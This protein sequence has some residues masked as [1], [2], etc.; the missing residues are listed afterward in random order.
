MRRWV[1]VN[2]A[3][4]HGLLRSV[5]SRERDCRLP[6]AGG[7]GGAILT[8]YEQR[9]SHITMEAITAPPQPDTVQ[10]P[11]LA[12]P[13]FPPKAWRLKPFPIGA[14]LLL[15]SSSRITTGHWRSKIPQRLWNKL[16]RVTY[17]M[18]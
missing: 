8:G 14:Q 4:K 18:E 10:F 7:L 15:D 2:A 12:R 6:S 9:G 5:D 13:K 3:M 11:D 1:G 17:I 16:V